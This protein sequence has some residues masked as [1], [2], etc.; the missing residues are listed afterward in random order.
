MLSKK[1]ITLPKLTSYVL[2]FT[3][4]NTNNDILDVVFP[5]QIKS[6]DEFQFSCLKFGE[7]KN[8]NDFPEKL[9]NIFDPYIKDIIRYGSRKTFENDINLSLY[10]SVLAQLIKNYE[11]F[12]LKDQLNYIT[13]LR[14][15]LIIYVSNGDIMQSQ[16]YDKLGWNKKDVTNSLIQF[17][18]NKLVMKLIADY[19]NINIFVLNIVEDKMYVVSEN[20]YYDMFRSNIF[21]VFNVDTFEPLIYSDSNLLE[22][23]SSPIKKLITVDKH[24]I[25]LMDA[26][27]I[28]H[29][30]L[31]FNIKLSNID[32]YS[33][34]I[35]ENVKPNNDNLNDNLNDNK[36]DDDNLNDKTNSSHEDI[37]MSQD[38]INNIID[39]E[40]EYGE[41]L[42]DESDA[43]A[44]I[45][46][47][48]GS[49]P[50]SK[51]NAKT[52]SVIDSTQLIFKIS[53]KMKLE[54]LQTIA[55]KLN[56]NIEKNNK[57]TTGKKKLIKTKGELIDEINGV[58]KN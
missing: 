24:F 4:D 18:S 9:K 7:S 6:N 27:L 10:Y 48:E 45:E 17:K 8:I 54:E 26:N 19:F 38:K 11:K 20:D 21:I 43:N 44:Y 15:K 49:D 50:K 33:K 35:P 30:P 12:P 32:K 13:K 29:Q 22:Y 36:Q 28:D 51:L 14:D 5:G 42:P 31:Q 57:Q 47:I 39:V 2:S 55:K 40:N 1:R 3:A 34:I 58:L 23:N 37:K 25:I 56:I 53:P 52:N 16:E 46:D 41:V